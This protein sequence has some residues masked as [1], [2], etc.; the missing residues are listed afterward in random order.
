MFHSMLRRV[1]PVVW[2]QESPESPAEGAERAA[3]NADATAPAADEGAE[4]SEPAPAKS[5]GKGKRGGSR[6][7]LRAPPFDQRE[8]MLRRV[9]SP[10]TFDGLQVEINKP[11]SPAFS[12]MHG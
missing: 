3:S 7:V 2:A 6:K 8:G 4:D 11:I 5:N 10:M 1:V 9:L 12:V